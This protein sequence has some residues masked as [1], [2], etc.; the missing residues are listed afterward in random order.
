M[1]NHGAQ[2][3]VAPLRKCLLRRPSWNRHSDHDWVD[4]WGYEREPDL[5]E[6]QDEHDKFADILRQLGVQVH[7]VKGQAEGLCDSVFTCDSALIT[8]EG[9]V[10][11][12]SGKSVRR[13][14]SAVV[15]EALQRLD[16][17][18]IYR[19]EKPMTA[20]GGD[21]IWLRRDL[22]LAGRSY[23][24][25]AS[26]GEEFIEFMADLGIEVKCMPVP[27][28]TGKDDVM[29]LASFISLLDYDLAVAYKKI[30]SVEMVQ[31]LQGQG[32]EFV[33]VSDDEFDMG[34]G[35]NVLA[36]GP[37]KCVMLKDYPRVRR[38][39][40]AAGVQVRVYTGEELSHCMKGGATCMT[41]DVLRE[42]EGD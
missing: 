13:G 31:F 38:D 26:H 36:V 15:E 25:N 23:R 2:S 17:P 20:D 18:I 28:W 5:K 4:T 37:G 30:M 34:L 42:Y 33:D 8:D 1:R 24:T 16:I 35:A 22:L 32:I 40:E 12:R 39:L 11:L 21:F 10:I 3:S 6:A 27:H 14:E 29:H 19:M 9:A 41:L 7:Y